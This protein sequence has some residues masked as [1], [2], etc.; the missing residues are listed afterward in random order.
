MALNWGIIE[1]AII[2]NPHEMDTGRRGRGR[3]RG[4]KENPNGDRCAAAV[5]SAANFLC[6]CLFARWT[7][8]RWPPMRP[9]RPLWSKE[10]INQR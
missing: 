9:A 10:I 4:K 2:N 1:S 5:E 7:I 6:R 8:K 3:G